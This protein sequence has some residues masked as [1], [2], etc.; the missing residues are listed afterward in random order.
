MVRWAFTYST[1]LFISEQKM[2]DGAWG[3]NQRLP[4]AAHRFGKFRQ[5]KISKSVFF[6]LRKIKG[7]R[8]TEFECKMVISSVMLVL[9]GVFK[10]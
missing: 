7:N 6:G 1:R 9:V 5:F 8:A 3:V 10:K 4:C 2:M